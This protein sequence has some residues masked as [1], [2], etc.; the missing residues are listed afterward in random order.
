[1]GEGSVGFSPTEAERVPVRKYGSRAVS[2]EPVLKLRGVLFV[3]KRAYQARRRS[4]PF[5]GL[6][7]RSNEAKGLF[8][9]NP[10]G[11]GSFVW[12]LRWLGRYSPLQGCSY[13]AA[14]V[15]RLGVTSFHYAN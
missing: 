11:G 9:E 8:R 12:G 7:P 10:A 6:R 4:I 14:F 3:P 2:C 5:R 13:L 1:M 15:W